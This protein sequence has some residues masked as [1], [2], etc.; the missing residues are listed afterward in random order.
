MND[1]I[2]PVDYG[3]L[4]YRCERDDTLLAI[5][6]VFSDDIVLNLNEKIKKNKIKKKTLLQ[7]G[8]TRRSVE[9]GQANNFFLGGP[10]LNEP[11]CVTLPGHTIADNANSKCHQQLD[12]I[13]NFFTC[14]H[15][16]NQ[17]KNSITLYTRE[18]RCNPVH[19]AYTCC[20]AQVSYSIRLS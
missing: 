20:D 13:L 17:Q 9:R 8:R 15:R 6:V 12:E 18:T 4:S 16:G 11:L 3:T 5:L 14:T 7:S 19:T 1:V 10:N 2:G